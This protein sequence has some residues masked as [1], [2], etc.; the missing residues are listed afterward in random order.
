MRFQVVTLFEELFAPFVRRGVVGRGV[1]AGIVQV[2]C[3]SPRRFGVGKHR[4]VDDKPYGGGAGMVMRVDCI[5]SCMEAFDAEYTAS[6][7]GA[8]AAGGATGAEP[9][10]TNA[11]V[12]RILLTPQGK[13]FDQ[14]AAER[15]SGLAAVTLVCGRYEGFD[16]RV[17]HFVDEELSLGDFVLSGGE[18][19]A[20]TVI[21]ACARLLPG[22]LGNAD[23][24]KQESFHA[25]AG[26]LE[27]PH[28]TRPAAYRGLEVPAVLQSGHHGR[29]ETWRQ[30]Q[31]ALRTRQRRPDLLSQDVRSKDVSSKCVAAGQVDP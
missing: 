22:V 30:Q 10:A 24:L 6:A 11:R 9:A 27:Y 18:L 31:A 4:A 19:A 12:K 7:G 2:S 13:R 14:R 16:E 26:L 21:D 20:M 17:R 28:Y 15:L 29:V 5:V 8:V 3:M 23:S 1:Q 25:G